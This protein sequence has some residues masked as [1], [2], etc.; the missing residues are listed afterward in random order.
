MIADTSAWVEYLRSTGSA[1]HLA[2]RGAIERGGSVVVP[3]LVVMEILVGAGDERMARRLRTLLH[4]FEVVPLA[5]L[6]DSERAAAL[7]RQCR[8]A[9]RPVRNMVDCMIA[10]MAIRL[11]E[12]VLHADRDFD[13]LATVTDLE[14]V[15]T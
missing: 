10:A 4:S 14:V 12:P 8:A 13:V 7:Q 9:G 3:E 11:S 15:T 6:L 1:P 5:P 2:L